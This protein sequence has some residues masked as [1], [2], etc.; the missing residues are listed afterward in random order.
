VIIASCGGYPKDINFIQSHKAI[1]NAAMFVKDGGLLL[2]YG[3]CRDGI[4]S[5]TFLP[6]FEMSSFDAAFKE[7]SCQYQGNGGTALAMMT[8]LQRI[9]IG[10]VTSL[11]DKTCKLIGIEHWTHD[12]VTAYLN[13]QVKNKTIAF[14]PNASLTVKKSERAQAVLIMNPNL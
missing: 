8:K 14:I 3:E 9:R 13:D 11:D 6:W 4:G 12:R 7:L 5:K 2:V 1:H 10:M